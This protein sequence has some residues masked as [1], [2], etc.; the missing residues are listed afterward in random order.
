MV[1]VNSCFAQ[2]AKNLL[3]PQFLTWYQQLKSF[4]GL[5][6][7]KKDAQTL[8]PHEA[9]LARAH[10]Y[11]Q[12]MLKRGGDPKAKAE[13]ESLALQYQLDEVDFEKVTIQQVFVSAMLQSF[14]ARASSLH[15]ERI[16]GLKA[17]KKAGLHLKFMRQHEN[18]FYEIK[19]LSTVYDALVTELNSN[20]L[21]LSV[22][23]MFPS[24]ANQNAFSTLKE[25]ALSD[26]CFVQTEALYFQFKILSTLRKN[27]DAAY[28]VIHTL[29]K[30]YPENLIIAIEALQLAP[31]KRHSEF[32]LK[33][34]ELIFRLENCQ[35]LSAKEKQ[36]LIDVVRQEHS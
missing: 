27:E 16:Q 22:T 24:A 28:S 14:Q 32:K 29:E 20:M 13:I 25:L 11:W 30:M 4:N 23:W 35:S 1:A 7:L 10:L 8:I 15:G 34:D 33:A 17:Y 6:V 9:D 26:N 36:H 5:D 2:K 19:L 12:Q 18:Q 31:H 21:Y 3:S